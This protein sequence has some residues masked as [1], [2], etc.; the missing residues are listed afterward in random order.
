MLLTLL[1]VPGDRPDRF[2]KA[3]DSGADAVIV[4]LEDAVVAA[5]KAYA[6]EAAAEFVAVPR[7]VPVFVRVNELTGPDLPA[8]LDALAGVPGL[9]GLRLPKV[10]SPEAVRAVAAR[11]SVPLHPLVESAVGVERAYEIA[12]ADPAVAS[13]GLGEADL[14][15]DLGVTAE[16]GLSWVRGRIVVAARAAGLP[17]P[18]L[19]AYANVT[20]LSGLAESC[21]A[22][23]RMGFLGRTAIHPRQLPVIVEAFRPSAEEVSRARELLDAVAEAQTRDSGTAVLP[24]GRFADRAMVAAARRTVEIAERYLSGS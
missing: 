3:V 23:R 14:R 2:G 19:P 6:R 8:D 15:S 24:D 4:D 1:Y 20:D 11:V 13:I 18:L 10:E 17:P 5:R 22:G 12:G 21:A 7:P 9:A 16:E